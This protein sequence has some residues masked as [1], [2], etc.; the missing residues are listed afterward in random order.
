ML[1]AFCLWGTAQAQM[2]GPV[3]G[4]STP[5]VFNGHPLLALADAGGLPSTERAETLIRRLQEALNRTPGQRPD[6]TTEAINGIPAL[7][8]NGMF[9]ITVCPED[10]TA[11]HLNQAELAGR[12]QDALQYGLT[13]A[14]QT[15]ADKSLHRALV[16]AGWALLVGLCLTPFVKI[17]VERYLRLPGWSVNGILWLAVLAYVLWRLPYTTRWGTELGTD[18][19]RPLVLL[20]FVGVATVLILY[21]CSRMVGRYFEAVDRMRTGAQVDWHWRHRL[22]MIRGAVMAIVRAVL[23]A[24]AFL[25]YLTLLHVNVAALATGAGLVGVV[26]G[27]AS[28]DLIKDITAGVN[29]ILEDQFGVGDMVA[30]GD[31]QGHVEAFTLRATAMRDAEGHLIIVPNG[32]MRIVKNLSAVPWR[33]LEMTFQL[34]GDDLKASLHHLET[35]VR[36]LETDGTHRVL[37]REGLQVTEKDGAVAVRVRL[38]CRPEVQQNLRTELLL[39][40]RDAFEGANLAIPTLDGVPSQPDLTAPHLHPSKP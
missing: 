5:V 31:Q 19:V 2:Q 25:I 20:V 23:V 21:V 6:V 37:A 7:S 15:E 3:F 18:V 8:A 11:S 22:E 14:W 12:W 30:S 27:V 36:D 33:W 38:Q 1:F 4:Q 9:L 34:A 13:N 39:R 28:Q 26:I 16:A 17:A 24:G 35:A 29:I 40:V 32:S 10:A